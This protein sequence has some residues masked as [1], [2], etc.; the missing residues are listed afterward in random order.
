[1]ELHPVSA[2]CYLNGGFKGLT[3]HVWLQMLYSLH[4]SLHRVKIINKKAFVEHNLKRGLA[5]PFTPKIQNLLGMI[6]LNL[7]EAGAS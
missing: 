2:V 7:I 4:T 6:L 5:G 3:D 1:M